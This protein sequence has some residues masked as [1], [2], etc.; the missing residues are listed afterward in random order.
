MPFAIVSI[1]KILDFFIF[2]FYAKQFKPTP[3]WNGA[4]SADRQAKALPQGGNGGE[5]RNHGKREKIAFMQFFPASF[6][7]KTRHTYLLTNDAP[8]MALLLLGKREKIAWFERHVVART[9]RGGL[10]SRRKKNNLRL[11]I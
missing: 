9:V 10:S 4:L 8:S 11:F 5:S 1:Y 6:L 3:D 7:S 2:R